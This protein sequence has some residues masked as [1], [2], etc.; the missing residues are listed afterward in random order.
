MNSNNKLFAWLVG[1]CA[2]LSL[3]PIWIGT[4]LPLT[5]FPQQVAQIA[6][7]KNWNNP[8]LHYPDYFTRHFFTPYGLST[9]IGFLF[10]LIFSSLVSAKIILSITVLLFPLSLYYLLT[11]SQ[12]NPCWSILGFPLAY[13]A[14]FFWGH[15]PFLF[16]VPLGFLGWGLALTYRRAPSIG[17]GL[18][19]MLILMVLFLSHLFVF[20]A[21]WAVVF[22]LLVTTNPRENIRHLTGPLI[23]PLVVALL[24]VATSKKDQY[25]GLPS[26][27]DVGWHRLF[28]FPQFIIGFDQDKFSKI[29]FSLLLISFLFFEKS[30]K[31][32]LRA[33]LPFLFFLSICLFAPFRLFNGANAF[34]Q[35][36]SVFIVPS[37]LLMFT[38]TSKG[39]ND[40]GALVLIAFVFSLWIGVMANRVRNFNTET[41]D[42]RHILG[43]MEPGKKLIGNVREGNSSVVSCMPYIHFPAYYQIFK[44]GIFEFSFSNNPQQVVLYKERT[45]L[46]PI[47]YGLRWETT[48]MKEGYDYFLIRSFDN[49]DVKLSAEARRHMHLKSHEGTWWLFERQPAA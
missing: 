10:S 23:V 26:Q 11:Q 32:S 3:V 14:N 17:K 25:F 46:S 24:W 18:G 48:S 33:H 49:E 43:A 40:K 8:S 1:L 27:W 37:A 19:L 15:L 5:D 4:F 22:M 16:A 20:A 21:S 31:Q 35:R 34:A 44:G 9:W 13:G 7:L 39:K 12:G 6:V 29:F 42:F 2:V 47:K 30:R 38:S 41:D 45:G 28:E 36:M